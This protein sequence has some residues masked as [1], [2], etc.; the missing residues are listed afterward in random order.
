MLWGGI[1]FDDVSFGLRLV[2]RSF[3]L[4]PGGS[5]TADVAPLALIRVGN[6]RSRPPSETGCIN[7]TVYEPMGSG[8]GLPPPEK[9]T[10]ELELPV[11]M[12]GTFWK[13][14]VRCASALLWWY[15]LCVTTLQ[16]H[17]RRSGVRRTLSSRAGNRWIALGTVRELRL[18]LSH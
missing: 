6:K 9:P 15:S 2:R 14:C 12:D 10:E 17:W 11:S 4:R 5:F 18:Q 7:V 8:S 16:A 3:T 1:P 13:L